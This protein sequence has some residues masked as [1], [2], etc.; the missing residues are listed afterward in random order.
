MSDPLGAFELLR[1]DAEDLANEESSNI[2]QYSLVLSE[3]LTQFTELNLTCY[4]LG[5][6]GAN[7][8]SSCLLNAGQLQS[9]YL[10]NNSLG[11]EGTKTIITGI[12][13]LRNLTLLDLSGNDIGDLG[14][15]ALVEMSRGYELR[16]LFLAQNCITE[17][18][19]LSISQYVASSSMLEVLHL[20]GNPFGDVGVSH[21]M[22]AFQPRKE[23][24]LRSLYLNATKTTDRSVH[25]IADVLRTIP[26]SLA[27]IQEI[28][29]EGNQ[30]TNI[31][32]AAITLL[33][34][35]EHVD[36]GFLGIGDFRKNVTNTS[37]RDR[38]GLNQI[39]EI[40]Q[41]MLKRQRDLEEEVK[42]LREEIR[43]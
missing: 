3:N 40:L 28:H 18:G 8:L 26:Q 2:A 25:N 17:N 11:P 27:G 29:F 30:L 37:Q 23:Y 9:L 33:S 39:R 20:Q 19:M 36:H 34:G 32:V 1:N 21:L 12:A 15:A 6:K 7:L 5:F 13:G 4:F 24:A 42:C 16:S 10:K 31:G 22:K 35:W 43:R 41:G 38:D 14:A